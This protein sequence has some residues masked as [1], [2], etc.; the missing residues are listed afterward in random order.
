VYAKKKNMID[1]RSVNAARGGIEAIQT[2]IENTQPGMG[3]TN[4]EMKDSRQ[5]IREE[6]EYWR[7]ESETDISANSTGRIKDMPLEKRPRELLMRLGVE[8]LT[9]PE[10]LAIVIRSGNS[11]ENVL[12]LAQRLYLTYPLHQLARC[13]TS[14]LS[15]TLGIG[16]AKA[17]QILASMELGF[18]LQSYE[19]KPIFT[20]PS[21]AAYFLM[22]ELSRLP[23]EHFKC[24]YLNR[25]NR[26]VHDRTL[27]IGTSG[28]SLVDP[29]VVLREALI[30][31]ASSI[32]LAHNHPT[33]DPT[34][35]SQ[36]IEMTKRINNAAGLLGIEIFDHI[37]IG[38]ESFVS[39]AEKGMMPERN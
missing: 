21:E 28:E 23:Q 22:P 16:N 27:F 34:P 14:E 8:K 19:S 39:Y 30:S 25:R 17:C 20:R 24:L 9:T 15:A 6:V 33:G 36:D 35:S 7:E 10:L 13:S 4:R 3:D 37:I 5:G 38:Q 32:I 1:Q 29:A 11:H 31:N 12:Q 18:R 2:R 26:L